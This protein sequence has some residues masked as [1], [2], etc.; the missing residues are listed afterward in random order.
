MKRM[1]M[2]KTIQPMLPTLYKCAFSYLEWL[3]ELKW[4]GFRAICFVDKGV[5]RFVSRNQRSLSEKFPV[6]QEGSKDVEAVTAIL[7]GEIVALDRL[8]RMGCRDSRVCVQDG[9]LKGV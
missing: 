8:I 7:D 2:P 5:V 6:L 9:K 4:D 1:A 3:F